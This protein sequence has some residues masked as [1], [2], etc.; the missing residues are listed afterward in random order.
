ML[1]G[2]DTDSIA[3]SHVPSSYANRNADLSSNEHLVA[4][5]VDWCAEFMKCVDN[6]LQCLISQ[7]YKDT[8][9][10]TYTH[11]PEAMHPYLR[12]CHFRGSSH[13][14]VVHPSALDA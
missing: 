1:A 12:L 8:S 3:D 14:T 10:I 7:T 13:I 4:H 5:H 6:E 2:S 9:I 11:Y